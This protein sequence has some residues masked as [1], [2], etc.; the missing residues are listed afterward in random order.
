MSTRLTYHGAASYEIVGPTHRILI[1]PFLSDNPLAPCSPDDLATP[2]VILVS[3]A[4]MDHYG[5]T[6]DVAKRTGAPVV[7]DAAVRAKLIDDGV[8][9][10]QITPTTWGIV[11]EIGGVVVRPVECHHW[12]MATLSDGRQVVGNP[13]A[14]IV[15][16]EPGVRIYHYGDTCIFDM[17]LIGELYKPTVG[18]LGCTLPRELEHLI[19]GPGTFLTGEMDADEAARAAEMLGVELAVACHYL[20]PD[21]EVARFLDL[22]P[23]YDT[24]GRRRVVAPLVG[25]TLVV[26]ATSHRIEANVDGT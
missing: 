5:D 14:F 22:V 1:D 26:D 10:D 15:E 25:E 2:D 20:A 23:K 7:C 4:A 19:P 6:P 18:L 12:S 17:R 21:D 3:H 11:V 9:P 16:T 13:I 8:S 24:T